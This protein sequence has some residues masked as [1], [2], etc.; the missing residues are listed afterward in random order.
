M[1]VQWYDQEF[2]VPDEMVQKYVRDLGVLPGSSHRD[3][4]YSMRRSINEIMG[5]VLKDPTLLYEEQHMKDFMKAL[6]TKKAMEIHGV[7]Y[8]A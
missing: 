2:D 7:M 1:M 4:V 3:L 5:C 6:A 8:D